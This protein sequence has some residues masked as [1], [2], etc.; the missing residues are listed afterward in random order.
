VGLETGVV[1]LRINEAIA[2]ISDAAL[3]V[4]TIKRA[5]ALG[6]RRANDDLAPADKARAK[7]A[8]RLRF[9]PAV[10]AVLTEGVEHFVTRWLRGGD[11][12]A[13]Y[14]L[15]GSTPSI[16]KGGTAAREG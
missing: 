15:M 11:V 13:A 8:S 7:A 14:R 3:L 5:V 16:I 9:V 2:R 1:N 10:A 4:L 6:Q 12:F